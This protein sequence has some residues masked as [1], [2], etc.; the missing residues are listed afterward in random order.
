MIFYGNN[1]KHTNILTKMVG[2]CGW[3]KWLQFGF[4]KKL[5]FSVQF[6]LYKIPHMPRRWRLLVIS[7]I[8]TNYPIPLFSTAS[9][10]SVV[11]TAAYLSLY[12]NCDSTTIRRYHDAFHYDGSDRNYDSTAIRLR[13][14]KWAWSLDVNHGDTWQYIINTLF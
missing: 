6:R 12:H 13:E 5:L 10:S 11:F 7:V 8:F 9:N 3:Q 2:V 4:A 1:F 14:E